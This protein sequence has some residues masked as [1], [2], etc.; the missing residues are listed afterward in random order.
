M[1]AGLGHGGLG[2]KP[3]SQCRLAAR[4]KRLLEKSEKQIPRG[5][6]FAPTSAKTALVGDPGSPARDD[7]NK[8]L[9]GAPKGAPFQNT[10]RSRLFQQPL[11]PCPFAGS[12]RTFI[13]QLSIIGHHEPWSKFRFRGSQKRNSRVSGES[14]GDCESSWRKKQIGR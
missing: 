10:C 14:Q 6:N 13:L 11:K 7:K 5:L 4:L 9:N 1:R 12:L 3:A 8:E 2:L